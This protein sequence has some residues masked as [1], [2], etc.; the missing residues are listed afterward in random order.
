MQY[1]G[2]I[3]P[4]FAS[5]YAGL[6]DAYIW[7]A[8]AGV[9]PANEGFPRARAAAQKALKLDEQLADGHVSLAAVMLQ[10]DWNWAGAE[11]EYRRAITLNPNSSG[12]H[13]GYGFYL[14]AMGRTDEAI[15]EAKRALDLDPLTTS[16]NVQLGWVLYYA[17]RHDESIAQLKKAL[18]LVPDHGY[19]YMELGWNYAQKRMYPEALAACQRAVRL[20]PEDQVV[21][22]SCGSVYAIAGERAEALKCLASL[23]SLSARGYVDPY[24]VAMIYDGLGEN[25]RTLEWFERAYRERSAS[26]VGLR[27]EIL[28]DSLRSD[29]RFQDL[30]HRMNFPQ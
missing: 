10:F 13:S 3:D 30:L 27:I 23:K 4:T 2:S 6:A 9:Q 14:T 11:Q 20:T 18:E 24:N 25:D 26:L 8:T 21:L 22:G 5:A 12:A 1:K 15:I 28:S 19:A 17:R 16:T 7:S 29:P